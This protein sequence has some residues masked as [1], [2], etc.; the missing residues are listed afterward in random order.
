MYIIACTRAP[1]GPKKGQ[2]RVLGITLARQNVFT[3]YVYS[4]PTFFGVP[5]RSRTVSGPN[6]TIWTAF[7]GGGVGAAIPA[8]PQKPPNCKKMFCQNGHKM[9]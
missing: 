9:G 1:M 2:K 5:D 6:G 7:Q 3:Q 4:F 8:E